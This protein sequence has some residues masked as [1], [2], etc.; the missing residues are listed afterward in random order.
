MQRSKSLIIGI[1][2]A[3]LFSASQAQASTAT[4]SPITNLS[5]VYY[6]CGCPP[7]G[8]FYTAPGG[9]SAGATNFMSARVYL[10]FMLPGYVAGTDITN[11]DFIFQVLSD[12][13]PN[14]IPYLTPLGVYQVGNNYDPNNIDP[15]NPPS[16][17]AGALIS[18][19]VAARG[20]YVHTNVTAIVNDAYHH[21]G[22]ISL[23]IGD[24]NYSYNNQQLSVAK[25]L[26]LT[27]SAVP[28][29]ESYAMMMAGLGLVAVAARR[30]KQAAR[31]AL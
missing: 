3:L 11:A 23:L 1:T 25:T 18:S 4:L 2:S 20:D 19:F 17:Q 27:I 21:G 8:G 28:E 10:Q 12:R 15:Y 5:I 30:R 13:D 6:D 16:A 9:D 29:P 24:H 31:P 26:D 22:M 14:Y 7:P